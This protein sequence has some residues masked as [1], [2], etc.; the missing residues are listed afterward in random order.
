MIKR[1]TLLFFTVIMH[2]VKYLITALILLVP[3]LSAAQIVQSQQYSTTTLTTLSTG[4]QV[5]TVT[6]GTQTLTTNEGQSTPVFAG[7]VTIRG[8]HGVCGEYFVQAFNGT[9]NQILS[10]SVSAN[11]T[12][13]VYLMTAPAFQA[14][15]HEV[16]AGGT[17]TPASP[18]ASQLGTTS[19]NYTVTIPANGVYDLVVHNLSTSTVVVQVNANLST[20]APAMVTVVAYS[21]V[22]Q[23]M[24]QTVMQTSVATMQATSSGPDPTTIAAIILVIV[25]VVVVALVVV[26]KRGKGK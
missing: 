19:Y 10:G 12:V 16:V 1:E 4:S 17:C 22:T 26:R 21:T 9:A 15:E 24:V 3:L 13:N 6:V 11:S 7:S 23:Q 20:S 8:S 18:V 14:W 5:N 2:R 25:V